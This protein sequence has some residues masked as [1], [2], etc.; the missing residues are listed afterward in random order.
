V[1]GAAVVP[2]SLAGMARCHR[3]DPGAGAVGRLR[4]RSRIGPTD[5]FTEVHTLRETPQTRQGYEP[6]Q[7]A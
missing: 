1:T 6:A 5:G 2:N 4:G 3:A 7:E